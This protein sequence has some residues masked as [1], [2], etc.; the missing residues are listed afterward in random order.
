MDTFSDEVWEIVG[1]QLCGMD[2][3]PVWD[4]DGT[5]TLKVAKDACIS[6]FDVLGAHK[7]VGTVAF[8][9][10]EPFSLPRTRAEAF[11]HRL[12]VRKVWCA[13]CFSLT[14]FC[15]LGPFEPLDC[16]CTRCSGGTFV[17]GSLAGVHP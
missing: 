3:I 17:V 14:S 12:G 15:C 2:A 13:L 6:G 10:L 5:V 11:L 4:G 7:R 9:A 8:E 16:S 1:R